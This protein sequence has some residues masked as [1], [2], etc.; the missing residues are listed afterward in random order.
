M[1]NKKG[2]ILG[3]A[4]DHSIAWGIAKA[5]H[6]QGAEMAFT[7]MGEALE[8]RVRTLAESLGAKI[9][10]PCN[11]TDSESLDN[12]FAEIE[13]KWGKIDFVVHAIAFSDKNELKGR[14]CDTSLANFLNSMHISCYSFTDICCRAAKIANP[15]ASFI[16]LSYLGAERVIPNYNVMGVAKAALETSVMYLARDLGEQEIR[17]NAISAGPIRTLA[18]AGIG[19]FKSILGWNR[20]NSFLPRNMTI[21]DVGNSALYLLSDLASGVT[22]E[23][24]HV[25]GGY[26]KQGMCNINKAQEISEIMGEYA[27]MKENN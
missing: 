4:N 21:E 15:G 12:L 7:Y 13:K 20:A 5:L 11:V 26:N 22:G 24:L 10:L 6:E 2:I 3:L 23:V 27:K 1:K 8:R 14:Y 9:I 17:V 25:D 18:S 16:T 19:D